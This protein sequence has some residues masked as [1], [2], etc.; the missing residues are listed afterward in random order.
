MWRPHFVFEGWSVFRASPN[1]RSA[2]SGQYETTFSS[3][4]VADPMRLLDEATETEA[5]SFP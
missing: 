4:P 1:S 3:G 5:A 2:R